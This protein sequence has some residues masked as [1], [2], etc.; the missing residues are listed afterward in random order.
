MALKHIIFDLD[1]TLVDTAPDLTRALNATFEGA[2]LAGIDAAAVRARVG[3]GARAMIEQGLAELGETL[4]EAGITALH[5]DFLAHYERDIS[6]DSRPF[7]GA[8]RVLQTF[9]DN[10]FQMS[11]CTNKPQ[12]LANKLLQNLEMRFFFSHLLGGDSLPQK[13]PDPAPVRAILRAAGVRPDDALMVG[14]TRTDLDAA[15]GAGVAVA[16]YRGGYS[17]DDLDALAADY[18]FEDYEVFAEF[19]EHLS[20]GRPS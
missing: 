15:R 13:K 4:E 18:Y 14:D 3:H 7:P 8:R 10:G 11:L 1:G 6:R 5:R 12:D 9:S 17:T 19:V 16:L 2:G 20:Q